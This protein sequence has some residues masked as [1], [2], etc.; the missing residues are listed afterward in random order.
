MA[1][2]VS[3][4]TRRRRL[5][6][7][8]LAGLVL[9]LVVG[10]VIGRSLSQGVGARVDSV[11]SQAASAVSALERLPIEYEQ[12]L[13]GSGGETTATITEAVARA[14]AQL[15]RAYAD[16]IWLTPDAPRATDAA[17]DSVADAVARRADLVEFQD[18]VDAAAAAIG[19]TFGL[20]P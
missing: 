9:G 4:G 7:V 5:I 16:A 10:V 14:R 2:Y 3:A 15:D 20:S 8:G 18:A 1:L 19:L 17:I 11:R 12:A 6:V 13:A